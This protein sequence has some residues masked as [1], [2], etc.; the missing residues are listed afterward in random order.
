MISFKD[1]MKENVTAGSGAIAG[2]GVNQDGSEYNAATAPSSF[3][4]PGM[5]PKTAKRYKKKNKEEAEEWQR[6]ITTMTT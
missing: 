3:G 6:K 1:F 2:I 4:E 5:K